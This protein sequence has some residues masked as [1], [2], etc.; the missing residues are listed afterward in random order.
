LPEIASGQPEDGSRG[1]GR[2]IASDGQSGMRKQQIFYVSRQLSD[3]THIYCSCCSLVASGLFG[4]NVA[5]SSLLPKAAMCGAT[6]DV[7]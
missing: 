2:Q 6:T 1:R 3:L 4:K 5:A 7:C